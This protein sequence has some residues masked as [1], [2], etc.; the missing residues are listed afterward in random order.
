MDLFAPVNP[1]VVDSWL[2]ALRMCRCGI[3]RSSLESVHLAVVG[4]EE[5]EVTDPFEAILEALTELWRQITR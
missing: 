5:I 2:A 1:L 3:G 4:E